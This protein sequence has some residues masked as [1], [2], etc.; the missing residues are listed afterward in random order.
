MEHTKHIWRVGILVI[1]AIT[2]FVFF[3][4]LLIP[5]SYGI[6]GSYRYDN[7]AEQ[8]A[9]EPR[10]GEVRGCNE[11]HDERVDELRAGP[12]ENVA[13]ENCHAP[14]ST[15]VK[16]DEKEWDMSVNKT[17]EW[18]VRCH[19]FLPARPK[20]HPQI[21]P[22]EHLV[23]VGVK[24][25]GRDWSDVVCFKCHEPHDPTPE[26]EDTVASGIDGNAK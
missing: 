7:V 12:H 15:H 18:C 24:Q 14:L 17:G 9:I 6:R 21:D 10:H 4:V 22:V 26:D 2:G 5:P 25:V 8:M 23:K 19:L 20:S 1:V 3:R 13:C 16:D 11:C